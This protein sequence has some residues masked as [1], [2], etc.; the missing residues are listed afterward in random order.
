M[1][2]LEFDF[3]VTASVIA[4]QHSFELSKEMTLVLRSEFVCLLYM[5]ICEMLVFAFIRSQ[6]NVLYSCETRCEAI[7]N[8]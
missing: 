8:L 4:K 2:Y 5:E 6:M 7:E 1:F 3:C